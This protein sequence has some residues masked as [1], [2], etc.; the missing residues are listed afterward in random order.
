MP[1]ISPR[2][3]FVR[4]PRLTFSERLST[5]CLLWLNSSD[6]IYLPCGVFSNQKCGNLRSTSIP[7]SSRYNSKP[8]S[9]G[10]RD[11]RSGS[12]EIIPSASPYTVNNLLNSARPGLAES[13]RLSP[14]DCPGKPVLAP[15]Q[16]HPLRLKRNSA[17]GNLKK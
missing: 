2:R 15:H 14:N 3:T 7:S 17:G 1:G 6:S 10:L 16:K 5:K 4:S 9:T 12:H 11:N 13:C 8:L